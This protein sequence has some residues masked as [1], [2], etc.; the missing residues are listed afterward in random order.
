MSNT[1]KG[2][3]ARN[4]ALWSVAVASVAVML[5]QM[6]PLASLLDRP[7]VEVRV[8]GLL[9]LSHYLGNIQTQMFIDLHNTGDRTA[10]VSSIDV[11]MLNKEQTDVWHLP[12]RTYYSR[13]MPA[14]PGQVMEYPI[15]LL[16]LRPGEVWSESIRCYELWDNREEREVNGIAYAIQKSIQTKLFE[17][18]RAPTD[19]YVPPV[20]ADEQA[21]SKAVEFFENKFDL[22]PGEYMLIVAARTGQYEESILDLRG[23]RFVIYDNHIDTLRSQVD[24]YRFGAGIY[25][26]ITDTLKFVS[27][28]RLEPIDSSEAVRL[29]EKHKNS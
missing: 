3:S 13:Q 24:D 17:R 25:Y 10:Y 9:S 1:I 21:V 12:A 8:N 7:Q 20:S 15:G 2:I 28:I 5:S 22:V 19:A 16:A 11:V 27:T 29:Y 23:F 6:P 26:P 14:Q 18:A 4:P